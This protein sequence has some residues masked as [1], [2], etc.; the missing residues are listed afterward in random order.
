MDNQ[1]K[2][3]KDQVP[4]RDNEPEETTSE[5]ELDA[6]LSDTFPASDPPAR[7]IKGTTRNPSPAER[8]R[9]EER[10]KHRK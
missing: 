8:K 3:R 2:D 7:V 4:E 9:R 10:E 1:P 6:A 5:E